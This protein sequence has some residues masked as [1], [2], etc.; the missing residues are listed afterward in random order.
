MKIREREQ[1]GHDHPTHQ[2]EEGVEPKHKLSHRNKLI[3]QEQFNE[4]MVDQYTGEVVYSDD[5]SKSKYEF[6]EGD[7]PNIRLTKEKKAMH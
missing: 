2:V 7:C 1:G 5:D 6:D 4:N 3:R